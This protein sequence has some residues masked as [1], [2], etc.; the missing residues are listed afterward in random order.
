MKRTLGI[1]ILSLFTLGCS[2]QGKQTV[3]GSAPAPK[4]DPK[5]DTSDKLTNVTDISKCLESGK[6]AAGIEGT[7]TASFIRGKVE[8]RQELI[9]RGNHTV[10][11]KLTCRFGGKAVTVMAQSAAAISPISIQ[12]LSNGGDEKPFFDGRG[13]AKCSVALRDGEIIDYQFLG[14]CVQLTS[15]LRNIMMIPATDRIENPE[16]Q[17]EDSKESP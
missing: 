17:D 3:S 11:N 1:V 12:I 7:W 15:P 9:I 6:P 2:Q 4:P 10:L 13:E 5:P 14:P 8:M 16:W